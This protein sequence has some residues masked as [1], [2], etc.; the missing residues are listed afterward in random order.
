MITTI[1]IVLALTWLWG[2]TVELRAHALRRQVD[3]MCGIEDCE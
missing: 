1:L 3:R 2:V